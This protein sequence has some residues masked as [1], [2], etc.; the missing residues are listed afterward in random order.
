MS[1]GSDEYVEMFEIGGPRAV[2]IK[3]GRRGFARVLV[4][5]MERAVKNLYNEGVRKIAVMGVGPM[6]Y[7]PR[8]LWDGRRRL[9]GKNCIE[10][11]NE[12]VSSYNDKLAERLLNLQSMLSGL[13]IVFC[14]IYR[15]MMEII[16]NSHTY[17]FSSVKNACCGV[18]DFGA[19][20]G[21]QN[22]EMSCSDPSSHIWW[23]FY[24]TT[25]AVNSL[26]AN[27]SWS[28][29]ESRLQICQPID[30]HQLLS[31]T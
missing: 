6:G 14:D 18:G 30:L 15:G 23:D 29:P 20:V 27:W 12:V 9:H 31:T 28:P 4:T 17:G 5:Q 7:A 11:V 16:S 3:F 8:I 21:C 19:M 26:L 2:G 22:L 1:F 10:E 25:E 24:S 13:Q